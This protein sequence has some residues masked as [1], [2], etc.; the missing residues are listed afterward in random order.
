MKW[1][2]SRITMWGLD[3]DG[4]DG[5]NMFLSSVVSLAK[6]LGAEIEPGKPLHGYQE[7]Y[8][9]VRGEV[10]L[11]A[12]FTAGT[13][14]AL[15]SCCFEA[16]HTAEEVYPVLQDMFPKHAIARLDAA[17]DYSGPGTWDKIEGIV[18]RICGEHRVTMAPYGEGHV[19]PDGTRDETKGR[20]WYCG[21]K[22]SPY[23]VVI[24]EKGLQKLAEGVPADPTWVRVEVRIKPNSK[25]KRLLG[26]VRLVPAQLY[27]ASR[28][29]MALGEALG[30]EDIERMVIGSVWKPSEREA[31]ALKIVRMFDRGMEQLL[32]QVGT[33]EE[34]GR[35]LYAV[36]QKYQLAKEAKGQIAAS[37]AAGLQSADTS[38]GD[39]PASLA[40]IDLGA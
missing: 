13:G 37:A 23:R 20:T 15:G 3:Q 27:G 40:G 22:S 12:C 34:V 21:S 9:L 32:D 10:L 30:M 36:H 24:Y 14:D 39:E 17:E 7:A 28:W 16:K 8:H 1:D 5:Q 38:P 26:S 29:G 33:P 25:A 35:L 6:T 2:Y 4:P 18:T 11:C 31:V 19:R